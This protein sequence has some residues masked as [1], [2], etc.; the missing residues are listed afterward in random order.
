MAIDSICDGIYG[1]CYSRTWYLRRRRTP[2]AKIRSEPENLSD[3]ESTKIWT[4]VVLSPSASLRINS[5]K[6]LGRLGPCEL[7][8]HEY[9]LIPGF[10]AASLLSRT[11]P[12][13]TNRIRNL[14][15]RNRRR[16]PLDLL[17][18]VG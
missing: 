12:V 13:K 15:L 9:A 2:I 17:F 16:R 10:F 7:P 11:Y 6:K 3:S 5:A 18:G 1:L 14:D 8:K 4:N